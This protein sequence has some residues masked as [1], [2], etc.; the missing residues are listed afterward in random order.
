MDIEKHS[1]LLLVD[2]TSNFFLLSDL[3]AD[4]ETSE[5]PGLFTYFHSVESGAR[6]RECADL[7]PQVVKSF[8]L[9][10]LH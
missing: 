5:G 6:N 10:P 7:S 3:V 2:L 8:L 9:P 1:H 4:R